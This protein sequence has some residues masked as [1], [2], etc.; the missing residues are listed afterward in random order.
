MPSPTA[1]TLWP[2]H[3]SFGA[4][5]TTPFNSAKLRHLTP[6]LTGLGRLPIPWTSGARRPLLFRC[7]EPPIAGI[8]G[9]NDVGGPAP[10]LAL[11]TRLPRVVPLSSCAAAGLRRLPCSVGLSGS[12][13]SPTLAAPGRRHRPPHDRQDWTGC[14]GTP[15]RWRPTGEP[16]MPDSLQPRPNGSATNQPRRRALR[17]HSSVS[18]RQPAYAPSHDRTKGDRTGRRWVSPDPYTLRRST[19]RAAALCLV[20]VGEGE[21]LVVI[22]RLLARKGSVLS[23]LTVRHPSISIFGVKTGL[24]PHSGGSG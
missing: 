16:A 19:A 8:P 21:A 6:R 15:P 9:C 20:G 7:V 2:A 4:A 3:I 14:R 5:R 23:C 1:P 17:A 22:W 13:R 12:C 18:Q 11:R 10:V 24:L